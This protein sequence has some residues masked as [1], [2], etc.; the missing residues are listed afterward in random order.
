M[1]YALHFTRQWHALNSC[2]EASTSQTPPTPASFNS[3]RKLAAEDKHFSLVWKAYTQVLQASSLI[4]SATSRDKHTRPPSGPLRRI[5]FSLGYEPCGY[6]YAE[7]GYTS[8]KTRNFTSTGKLRKRSFAQPSL[9]IILCLIFENPMQ[10]S[11][12]CS[13]LR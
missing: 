11:E 8:C 10:G 3:M 5:P 12:D 4:H 13:D 1:T 2:R 6:T 9:S 7:C